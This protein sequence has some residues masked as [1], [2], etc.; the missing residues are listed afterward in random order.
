MFVV[1][2]IIDNLFMKRLDRKS[3]GS[4]AFIEGGVFV[5]MCIT[6]YTGNHSDASHGKNLQLE[7]TACGHILLIP[8]VFIPK[9]FGSPNIMFI[10]N[11][12]V[13]TKASENT[14]LLL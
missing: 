5:M 12:N 9:L 11:S 2:M 7:R 13:N 4:K 1:L 6:V 8:N 10:Y 14:C 3:D